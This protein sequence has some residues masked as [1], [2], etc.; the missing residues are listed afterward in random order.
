[1]WYFS[2]NVLWWELHASTKATPPLCRQRCLVLVLSALC[3]AENLHA[4]NG[5]LRKES[6]AIP[7]PTVSKNWTQFLLSSIPAHTHTTGIHCLW[8]ELKP[9]EFLWDTAVTVLPQWFRPF[10]FVSLCMYSTT[11][12]LYFI[13]CFAIN[14]HGRD[15]LFC[16]I[17]CKYAPR[18]TSMA[19]SD[20]N[21]EITVSNAARKRLVRVY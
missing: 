2:S 13:P 3:E 11:C 14:Y 5:H 1:M 6:S 7:L 4:G 16:C 12:L 18:L 20:E 9:P 19:I 17:A 8:R 15:G 21:E 10:L